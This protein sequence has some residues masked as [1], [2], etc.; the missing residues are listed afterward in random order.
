MPMV[1]INNQTKNKNSKKKLKQTKDK[2]STNY[3]S[4]F[5]FCLF[6]LSNVSI[7][8]MKFSHK[9]DNIIKNDTSINFKHE[10]LSQTLAK[11]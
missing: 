3:A 5:T 7:L 6:K 10:I 1:S 8:N 2:Y 4:Y 11:R 9:S